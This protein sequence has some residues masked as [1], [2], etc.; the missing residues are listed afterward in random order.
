VWYWASPIEAKLCAGSEVVLVGGGNSAG[1]AAVFLSGYV[2]KLWMLVRGP[3][4]AVSMSSYLVE[5]IA[6]ISNI[7]LLNETEI[8][9]L[10]GTHETGL[11]AVRWRHHPTGKETSR[12]I[13]NV[14]VF[15]GAD[16]ATEWLASCGVDVDKSGFI[17]TGADTTK[18]AGAANVEKPLAHETN[19][20]RVFAVGDVRYGSVKRVGAGIGEGAA[21]VPQLHSRL[22]AKVG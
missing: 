22:A 5:R 14:F 10:G 18:P 9:E 8:V 16:P 12:P 15:I 11:D 17:K 6:A 3:G 2:S 4:L 21:V 13:R 19:L 20:P 1:Q 7:E